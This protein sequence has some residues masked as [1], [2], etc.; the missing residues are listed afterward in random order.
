METIKY[1]LE[2]DSN[3]AYSSL[4]PML[5][6]ELEKMGISVIDYRYSPTLGHMEI[7][8]ESKEDV[9]MWKLKYE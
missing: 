4:A 3:W 6:R 2:Y 9:L 1:Q 5:I 8:V 7:D